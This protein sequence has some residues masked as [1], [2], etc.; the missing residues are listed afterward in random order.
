M[1]PSYFEDSIELI[2]KYS[3]NEK[4]IYIISKYDNFLPLISERYSA[5]PVIDF[6]WY[7]VTKQ[8]YEDIIDF[9]KET[10]PKYIFADR[11]FAYRNFEYDIVN[12]DSYARYF[13]GESLARV[14]RLKNMQSAAQEITKDYSAIESSLLLT[15]YERKNS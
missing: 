9:F 3:P 12:Y 14:Q 13:Y 11:D 1:N 4:G 10:E 5:L 15:V 8:D 2:K 6:Q 7:V